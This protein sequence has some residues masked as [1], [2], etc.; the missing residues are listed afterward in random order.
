MYEL[1]ILSLLMRGP[2]HGYLIAHIVNN[3]IGP[4]ARMSNGRLY[5]L[6]ARLEQGGLIKVNE[7]VAREQHGERTSRSYRI[8]EAG[9]ERFHV[10]MMDTTSNPGEYQRIFHQKAAMFSF[11]Q[12]SERLF[13]INH[14]LN[15]CQAHV[16]HLIAEKED[17]AKSNYSHYQG[18]EWGL[19][20]TLDVMQ[21]M[22]DQWRLEVA[23]AQRLQAREQARQASSGQPQL[24]F[25]Y[26]ELAER[27]RSNQ[28][29]NE[30]ENTNEH[31][32]L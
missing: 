1:I 3:I 12:V 23:W 8:T 6:L 17:L 25:S 19:S 21:H 29:L 15:Y 24:H 28:N 2:A 13:L 7:E 16:L 31:N 5:P 10:L 4:Y 11:L 32:E 14:Y 26:V 30:N 18:D 27:K 22:A 9:R 20:G